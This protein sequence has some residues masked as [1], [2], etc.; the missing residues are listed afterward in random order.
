MSR[1]A[2]IRSVPVA[3]TNESG[4]NGPDKMFVVDL[5]ENNKLVQTRELRG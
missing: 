4:S 2:E 3:G 5:F 1:K